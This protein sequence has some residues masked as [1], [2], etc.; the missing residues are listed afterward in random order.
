MIHTV[1]AKTSLQT[2]IKAFFEAYKTD[3]LALHTTQWNEEDL[4]GK[5]YTQWKIQLYYDLLYLCIIL[6][7]EKQRLANLKSWSYFITTYSLNTIRECLACEGIVMQKGLDAFY[8]GG[9]NEDLGVELMEV[10]NNFEVQS[11]DLNVA[12][13]TVKELL[14]NPSSCVNKIALDEVPQ[15]LEE[16]SRYFDTLQDTI[17]NNHNGQVFDNE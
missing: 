3:I 11:P 7:L 13:I 14:A 9:T 2:N 8:L 16:V 15:T 4:K 6:Y 12:A 17:T 5:S 10:E 1:V